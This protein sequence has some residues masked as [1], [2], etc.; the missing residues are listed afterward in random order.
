MFILKCIN[1]IVMEKFSKAEKLLLAIINLYIKIT[2]NYG[3]TTKYTP[4]NQNF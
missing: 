3:L 1:L 4:K 2:G